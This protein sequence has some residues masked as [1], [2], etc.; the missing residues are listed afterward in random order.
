MHTI[1]CL[2]YKINSFTV[3]E[4]QDFYSIRIAFKQQLNT[5]RTAQTFRKTNFLF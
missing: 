4:T 3:S 1:L 5:F 2:F